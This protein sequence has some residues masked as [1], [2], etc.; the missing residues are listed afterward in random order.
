MTH[1]WDINHTRSEQPIIGRFL[2]AI[3][4]YSANPSLVEVLAYIG[5]LGQATFRQLDQRKEVN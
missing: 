4:G 2:T 3:F 1:V 5:Y